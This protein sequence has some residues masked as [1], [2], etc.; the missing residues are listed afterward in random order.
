MQ[1]L[2]LLRHNCESALSRIL[3]HIQPGITVVSDLGGQF[4]NCQRLKA[5]VGGKE[6]AARLKCNLAELDSFQTAISMAVNIS[7]AA[8][9]DATNQNSFIAHL[10]LLSWLE[11]F[12]VRLFGDALKL[13]IELQF[14]EDRGRCQVRA[15]ELILRDLINESYQTQQAL[16][17]QLAELF[18]DEIVGKWRS[19][20]D[21]GNILTG[22]TFS[23]LASLYCNKQEFDRYM[24]FYEKTVFLTLFSEKRRTIQ[25]YLE[26]I[27][28]IRNHFAHNKH[29]S[30]VSLY[31]LDLYFK[32]LI[33][34]VVEA[35]RQGHT[36]VNPD[37][38]QNVPL[39]EINNYFEGIRTDLQS[40]KEDIRDLKETLLIS[41]KDIQSTTTKTAT[42]AGEI[43]SKAARIEKT[44]R[45]LSFRLFLIGCTI[46]A[47]LLTAMITLHLVTGNKD[48]AKQILREVGDSSKSVA[49]I[50]DEVKNS[51]EVSRDALAKIDEGN[52]VLKQVAS[53]TKT[54]K[55]SVGALEKS[56]QSLDDLTRE[57]KRLVSS[58]DLVAHPETP[59]EIYHNARLH[60][61][62]GEVDIALKMYQEFFRFQLQYADPVED[63]VALLR[64]RYGA[65]GLTNTINKLFFNKLSPDL[66]G[67]ALVIADTDKARQDAA[68]RNYANQQSPYPPT[69]LALIGDLS[70]GISGQTISSQ[71]LVNRFK[72]YG[73]KLKGSGQLTKYYIDQILYSGRVAVLDDENIVLKPFVSAF[74]YNSG[75]VSISVEPH[76]LKT[77]ADFWVVLNGSFGSKKINICND[78]RGDAFFYGTHDE[79]FPKI[80]SGVVF[81]E[82][83]FTEVT[84]VSINQFFRIVKSK[85]IYDTS[86]E[87]VKAGVLRYFKDRETF[88]M[89]RARELRPK[90]LNETKAQGI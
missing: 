72:D 1:K 86:E 40:V 59:V 63:V 74:V 6:F 80:D 88:E 64:G 38:Y 35:A 17:Q 46:M 28:R 12:W 51:A 81:V 36:R 75:V 31:L 11:T 47:G 9:S 83:N 89:E 76:P 20:A 55:E 71:A 56:S 67:Y 61:Q 48:T 44:T 85:T 68:F 25:Q 73:R 54:I 49:R 23:E 78:L 13:P 50:A 22:T 43:N 7:T 79:K 26:D 70:S 53:E 39:A 41:F 5:K 82:L 3:A 33:E 8:P 16:I 2:N 21:P 57:L 29:L 10:R 24:R 19:S 4:S 14:S 60:A 58:N 52:Q 77:G 18:G 34:P 27:R 87:Q 90:G 30:D 42:I 84:G 37:V 65:I 69:I 15:L 32:E 45:S 66:L 62:R